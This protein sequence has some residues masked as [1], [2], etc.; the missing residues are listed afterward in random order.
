MLL[1]S[2]LDLDTMTIPNTKNIGFI[3]ETNS[4]Y[5]LSTTWLNK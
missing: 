5:F 4:K 1:G 3:N 2:D